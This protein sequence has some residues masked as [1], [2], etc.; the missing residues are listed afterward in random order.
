MYVEDLILLAGGFEI[1]ADQKQVSI[2][3]LEINND[4]E[5]I[6]RKYNYSVDTNYLKGISNEP[7][8]KFKLQDK[9]ILTIKKMLGYDE[10][11]KVKVTGEVNYEQTVILE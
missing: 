3:R 2:N 10:P 7:K 9:D 4:D 1:E 8:N 6:I 5:R 11:S